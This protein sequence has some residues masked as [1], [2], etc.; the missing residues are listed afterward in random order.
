MIRM[1]MKKL[2]V[3]LSHSQL[4]RFLQGV[5][6]SSALRKHDSELR[7]VYDMLADDLSRKTFSAVIQ[8][9]KSGDYSKIH[10]VN[11]QPQYFLKDICPPQNREIYVDGGGYDGKDVLRF[12]TGYVPDISTCKAYIWEP[13]AENIAK[14]SRTL[15]DFTN[16]EVKPFAMWSGKDELHFSGTGS[17]ISQ[18][19]K[20]GQVTV[21]ADSIDNQHLAE[22]VT[23]I[24]MDIEGAEPQALRGAERTI[25]KYRPKLAICIYHQPSHLYEI[26][27]WIKSV[28]PEYRIYIRHHSDRQ[29]ETVCYAVI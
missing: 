4:A 24:K 20:F 22:P 14:I 1:G 23:F 19:S 13:D 10:S 17:Q 2:A 18:V 25:I 27:L 8:A 29:A 15:H 6:Y 9:S 26:P 28:V 3:K 7:Q 21:Q 12:F 5:N 11:V 16:Y